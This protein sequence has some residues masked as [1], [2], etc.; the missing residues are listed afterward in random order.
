MK[1]SKKLMLVLALVLMTLVS[2]IPA[3]FSWYTHNNNLD[4]QKLNYTQ[5]LPISVKS[6]SSSVTVSTYEADAYGNYKRDNEDHTISATSINVT[7]NEKVKY[8][9]TTFTN[10]GDNDVM[11]DLETTNLRNN[12]DFYVGTLSPTLNEKAFASRAART[13]ATYNTVRVYFKS[14]ENFY[15]YWTTY[16]DTSNSNDSDY[17]DKLTYVNFNN[18]STF[19]NDMNVGYRIPGEA[20]DSY[21]KLTICP[22]Y[23]SNINTLSVN[24]HSQ[25][26]NIHD[27]TQ[28]EQRI[29]QVKTAISSTVFYADIP[30]NAEY[31]YFFN[32]YYIT[33]SDNKEWNQTVRITDLT[34]GRLYTMT[35]SSIEGNY[36]G[37]TVTTD[38]NLVDVNQYYTNVRMSLG[39]DVFADISLHK[40]GEGENFVPDYYGKTITYSSNK[41]GKA[42]VSRDGLITPKG[43]SDTND[44]TKITTKIVGEYGD[45]IDL[46]T[47]VDI[48][49]N[50]AQV[51]IIKNVLVPAGKSVDVHWYALNKH[52]S[53]TMTTNALFFTL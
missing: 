40:T 18:T 9:K 49:Q 33:A 22:N 16:V 38:T 52:S 43:Y 31:F 46:E 45:Y 21:L 29:N 26:N 37:H 36:K 35:G 39:N 3:T 34:G 51:P 30:S 15:P 47:V 8:Y 25:I 11:V 28:K 24:N 13:K 23:A 7:A 53:D 19:K 27:N 5:E 32:H 20:N 14:N 2:C 44:P 41:P 1:I 6:P 48:P 10:T 12:A 4:G 17:Q 42:T 50:I